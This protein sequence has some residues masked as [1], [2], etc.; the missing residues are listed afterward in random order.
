M[1]GEFEDEV[2]DMISRR[3][4]ALVLVV[5]SGVHYVVKIRLCQHGVASPKRSVGSHEARLGDDS[6]ALG[7]CI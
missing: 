6:M 5:T 3:R 1:Q 7:A 4:S 2:A